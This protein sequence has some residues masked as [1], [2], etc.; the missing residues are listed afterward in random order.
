M[1][2]NSVNAH[3]HEIVAAI[4]E[5]LAGNAEPVAALTSSPDPMVQY[6]SIA[7]TAATI[8]WTSHE[9]GRSEEEILDELAASYDR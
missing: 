8:R 1:S 6:T 9:T 4:R 5:L 2:D 7:L 3:G